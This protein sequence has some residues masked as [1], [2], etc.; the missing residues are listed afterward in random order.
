MGLTRITNDDE[1]ARVV[2]SGTSPQTG[3][4]I[5]GRVGT[6]QGVRRRYG[7]DAVEVLWDGDTESDY[8]KQAN[9]SGTGMR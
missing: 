7:E 4:R 3:R 9:V 1:G 5:Q 8:V 6:V 2:G